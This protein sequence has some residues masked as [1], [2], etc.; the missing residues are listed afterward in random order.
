M[1][2]GLLKLVVFLFKAGKAFPFFLDN[3]PWSFFNELGV[4][5]PLGKGFSGLPLLFNLSEDPFF[6]LFDI[7]EI[8]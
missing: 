6:F 8:A 5:K 4:L 2:D 1:G 7:D 3:I